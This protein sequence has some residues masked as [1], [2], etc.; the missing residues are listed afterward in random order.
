MKFLKYVVM[1][2]IFGLTT[3]IFAQLENSILEDE[4]IISRDYVTA[5][6]LNMSRANR[7]I[8]VRG[9]SSGKTRKFT[10]PE[11][12]LITVSGKDARFKD[13][14]KGDVV[15]LSMRPNISHNVISRIKVP[16]T[17]VTLADR[18]TNP[19]VEQRPVMNEVLPTVLPKT[20][21]KLSF[22]LLLG[23]LSLL[24]GGLLARRRI[25][26]IK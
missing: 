5:E 24:L 3:N 19:V 23:V 15:L 26:K 8:T 16:E 20:A 10:I 1:V 9:E 12:A 7:T 21:S 18:Q 13:L 22:I 17:T 4:Y 11:G 14:R 6:I 2:L 25:F